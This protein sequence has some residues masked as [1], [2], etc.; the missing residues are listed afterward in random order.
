VQQLALIAAYKVKA[1][2]RDG[3]T[4]VEICNHLKEL[5]AALKEKNYRGLKGE[6]AVYYG[7]VGVAIARFRPDEH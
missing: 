3:Y 1:A 2:Y 4:A 6:E 5:L 7:E